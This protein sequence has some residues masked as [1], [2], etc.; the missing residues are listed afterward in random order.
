MATSPEPPPFQESS[1]CDVCKCSFTTFRRRHHCRCCG[2]TLCHEHSS[3][4]MPLPQFDINM[5]V[6]VCY[7]CFN[8]SSRNSASV[9][10]ADNSNAVAEAISTLDI[11]EDSE[12]K[13]M[14][15]QEENSSLTK[16]ECKCGMPLC[17]CEASTPSCGQSSVQGL[18]LSSSAPPT[19]KI[20][21]TDAIPKSTRSTQDTRRSSNSGFG[22]SSR[23]DNS[24]VNYELNGEGLRDAIKNHDTYAVME[25]LRKGVDPNFCDKQGL[26]LLHLAAVFNHT[27]IAL[28]LMEHGAKTECKNSQGETPMDCAPPTLQYKMR[29]KMEEGSKH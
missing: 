14:P 13:I 28:A 21:R 29:M 22:Q 23:L 15:L 1:R 4:H 19:S 9:S 3:Y 24:Y 12:T 20:K 6:R 7:D 8:Y 16:L 26:S 10:Y 5:D 17:I 18:A 25:L 27:D 11:S 2:R